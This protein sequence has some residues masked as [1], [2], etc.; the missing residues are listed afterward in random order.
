MLRW[1]EAKIASAA[2]E[3]L[4]NSANYLLFKPETQL[5][6]SKLHARMKITK[7]L[8][9]YLNHYFDEIT[10]YGNYDERAELCLKNVR[11]YEEF[12]TQLSK[13]ISQLLDASEK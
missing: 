9:T 10:L 12:L 8:V 6:L 11:R 7:E 5:L 1:M 4:L 3:S 13:E 2:Y